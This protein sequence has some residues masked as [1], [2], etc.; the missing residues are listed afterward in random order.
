MTSKTLTLVFELS[1]EKGQSWRYK[2]TDPGPVLGGVYFSKVAMYFWQDGKA[3]EQ[4]KVTIEAVNT[5]AKR[6]SNVRSEV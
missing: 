2:E 4:L 5:P 6:G 3:P 1:D